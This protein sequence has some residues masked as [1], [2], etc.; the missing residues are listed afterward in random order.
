MP[1]AKRQN[2]PAARIV[3]DVMTTDVVTIDPDAQVARAIELLA[4]SHVSGIAVIDHHHKLVGVVST[5]DVVSAEAEAGD[6]EGRSRFLATAVVSD[7]MTT[8]PLTASPDLELREAALQMDYGDVHR[9]FV[10]ENGRLVGVISRS[11]INRA[12]AAGQIR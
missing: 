8:K 1:N 11:D 2:G 9:L 12:F 4:D 5:S 3:R 7:V 10:E 6:D